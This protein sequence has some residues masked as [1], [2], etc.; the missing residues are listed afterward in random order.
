MQKIFI[1]MILIF[2]NFDI[3]LGN[4][5]IGL[6]PDFVGYI[7]MY[8]GAIELFEF[9]DKFQQITPYIKGMAIYSGLCYAVDLFG[10]LSNIDPLVVYSLGF[11]STVFSL[12]ISY[13]IIHAIKD[14]EI[15]AGHD[16]NSIQLYSTWKILAVFSLVCFIPFPTLLFVSIFISFIVGCYYLYMF[17]KTK[18]LFYEKF[19]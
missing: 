15:R 17:S 14:I 13:K 18:N 2:L 12:L 1:G 7:Y 16:L 9:S 11:I 5:K 4:C 10:I 3:N 6:I 8:K 19:M